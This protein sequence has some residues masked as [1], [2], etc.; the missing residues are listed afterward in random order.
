MESKVIGNPNQTEKHITPPTD[1]Q[2]VDKSKQ[3]NQKLKIRIP[4]TSLL[5]GRGFKAESN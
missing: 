5:A 4:Y 1:L 2:N 3:K